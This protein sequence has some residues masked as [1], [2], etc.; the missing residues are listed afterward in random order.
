MQDAISSSFWLL[1]GL[2]IYAYVMARMVS[3]GWF[4]AKFAHH[5]KVLAEHKLLGREEKES[6]NG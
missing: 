5:R 4:A 3:A 1:V 6:G 2:P